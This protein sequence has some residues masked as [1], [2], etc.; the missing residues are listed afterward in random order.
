MKITKLTIHDFLKLKD[1]ELNPSHTNVIVGKNKM[2]KTSILKAIRAAFDGKI[3][4]SSIRIGG[5][6]AEITIELDNL[7]IRRTITEKGTY[8]NVSNKEG[9]S[10]P[11]PQRFLD[12]ILGTFSF[13]PIEFFELKPSDRKKYLLN[14]IK[15]TLTQEELAEFTGEKLAGIDYSLH[16]LEVLE[17][18]RKHYYDQRAIANAEVQKKEKTVMELGSKIPDGFDP[19]AV[20]LEKITALRKSI[21]DNAV[22]KE[23]LQ[24]YQSQIQRNIASI[25]E[26]KEKIANLV[27]QNQVMQKEVDGIVLENT[28]ELELELA[29]LESQRDLLHTYEQ[30][31]TTR[32]EWN[33][34]TEL[35]ERLDNIVKTLS[36]RAPDTLIAKAELPVP[37][38]TIEGN[39]I[40]I[41][42]VSL[43]NLSG[44][45]QLKFGLEIVKKLNQTFRVICIDG[46]ET[47]D[48]ETFAKFLKMIES[49]DY[50]YFVTRVDGN[51]VNSVVVEDGEIK[52]GLETTNP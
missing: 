21:T 46:I 32:K 31:E 11:A 20:S 15:M 7:N 34:A 43:D 40:L 29:T 39:D 42:G 8:L 12:G 9:F 19:K 49:D 52:N 14:A 17:I 4:E 10:V 50:Q 37:G 35:A 26:L 1:V 33:D 48:I 2:G 45:E 36:K 41:N 44:S 22:A 5:D 25:N 38:L 24:S 47:L 6:K 18:A 27:E 28:V 51:T 3:D 16:A 13:N 30:V 23:Q